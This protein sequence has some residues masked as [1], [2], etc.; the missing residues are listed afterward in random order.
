MKHCHFIVAVL[1]LSLASGCDLSKDPVDYVNPYAGNISHLLV[2]TFPTVQLPNSMLRVYPERSDY[3]SEYLNGLPVIVTNHRERSAFKLSVANVS[4]QQPARGPVIRTSY[5]NEHL[6][7]YSFE[8]TL[9]DGKIDARYALSH[10]SA[11]YSL[12][13]DDPFAVL[14]ASRGGKVEWN[15]EALEGW[16][17]VEGETKVYLFLEPEVLPLKADSVDDGEN[18]WV[19]LVFDRPEVRL[20]YGVSFIDAAQA[21]ANLRREI[22]GYD[23]DALAA[24][25][26]KIWNETLGR[27]K[28]KGAE[29]RK[30]VFY[31]SYYRTFE[32]PICLS[33]DGRY[34]S[35]FDNKVH[36]DGGTPFYTDDWIW[37]TYRAAHPLRTLMD[38]PL[39]EDILASYLR[40]ADQ[41]GTGWM[42]TFPEVSGDSRRMNSN[43]GIPTFADAVSK[44]LKVDAKAAFEAGKKALTEKTLVP[45]SGNP[46][47]EI[48]GFYWEHGYIPALREGEVETDPNVGWENR[49]PVAV[50]LGTAYDSWAL[51][52]LA[53]AAGNKEEAA[54]FRE[55]SG[56]YALLFNP[57]TLF[58]HPRDKEGNFIPDLDYNF[59]GGMG[60]REYYDE[61]NAWVYRWDVQHDI[62]GL[63]YLMGG[64]E[65]FC[66]ELDRMFATP[67]GMSKFRF[68]AKLPDHTG[69]VG[70][71]SMANEPSLHVPY[72]YNYAGAPWKTQKRVRQ[73]LDTWFRD[74]LMGVPGDEDGGGMTSFVVFSSLG[75][76][77]VTPGEAVYTIGSP[78][79]PEAVMKL[80]NGKT[81][82]L[83]AR[84]VSDDNKYIQRATLNGKPLEG[85]W[86]SHE[87]IMSG[88]TLILEMGSLPNKEWGAV[89]PSD[90][91]EWDAAGWEW[92]EVED[93]AEYAYAQFPFRR[94]TQSISM[95]RYPSAKRET[96]LVHAPGE[97]ANTTDSIARREGARIALNGS[98]FN[99]RRLTP[100]TFFSIDGEILGQTPATSESRSNGVLAI[101]DREGHQL[102]ILQYDSTK[103]EAY[104]TGYHSALASGP[105]LRLGGE[106]PAIDMGSSFN[107][108]RH[109]RT[110]IGWD[111]KGE[112]YMIVVDGRFPGQAD[113]MSIMELIAM[114]RLLGLK[115]ALNLDG[116][117]SST[118]WTDKT[119]I[120]NFPYDNRVFDHEGARKVPN[121]VVVK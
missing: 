24:E 48:D 1:V 17:T 88:G 38:Q 109:P 21:E 36:E 69:N 75:F 7:P 83:V 110:V 67:L 85:P 41:M 71:F 4:A 114:T 28:V 16:Q 91:N 62:P 34:W 81:F 95:V 50:S 51:S 46:A 82:K 2:P 120:I 60:A 19:T 118:L 52:K 32:R 102:E 37:D 9:A 58:F 79:F 31:T 89:I 6:T 77:P 55:W 22:A 43:H 78:V 54:Y 14:V 15:G 23:I 106:V 92:K 25:G 11:I 104:R 63:V 99:M 61:N 94:S 33:E 112:V 74:D 12:K 30:R 90:R 119:G 116:G 111:D 3:T 65:R 56:K 96:A 29:K 44:G 108:M 87:E 80:S 39:E 86:I 53:E 20:R 97:M 35:A 47:G 26:R 103:V 73:M 49:Q 10:Q 42:P 70:Q 107:Y 93:G 98:Y 115:D 100:H 117:G 18:S 59:P 113:G 57:E 40:M 5:D 27:I 105:I 45:W 72:L 13:S 84:N 101:K 68:F 121:I 66:M 64:P 8:V 76:Y